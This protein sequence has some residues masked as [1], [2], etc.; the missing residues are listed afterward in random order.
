MFIVKVIPFVSSFRL[1]PQDA[2]MV[3]RVRDMHALSLS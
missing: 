2:L 3:H 1:F